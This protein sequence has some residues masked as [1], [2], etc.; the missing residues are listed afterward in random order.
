MLFLP[1]QKFL[2]IFHQNL[3]VLEMVRDISLFQNSKL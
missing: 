2:A 1:Q 3:A